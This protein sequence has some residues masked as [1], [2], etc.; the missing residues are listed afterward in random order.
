[1]NKQVS[2][3]IRPA[4]MTDAETI[5]TFN[6]AL[7]RET[8]ARILDS[9]LL[10]AGVETLLQD[11][12]KGWYAVAVNC[13]DTGQATVVGQILITYEW[14]DWRNGNFWWIQSLY[15]DPNYR[16]HGVFRQLFE[17]VYEQAKANPEKVCGFRLYVERDNEQAHQI[18]A[19][20]GFQ[21]TAYLMHEIDFTE[22]PT[23]SPTTTI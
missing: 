8:E 10:K 14:S 5:R 15:V 18:Y 22:K 1:M 3:Q 20:M 19:H 11:F 6:A 4:S 2:I 16:Q 21:H 23:S 13:R 7:A 9:Q 12:S 17:Y